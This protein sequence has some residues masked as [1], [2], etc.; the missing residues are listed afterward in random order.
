MSHRIDCTS[1]HRQSQTHFLTSDNCK[2]AKPLCTFRSRL[3]TE[4]FHIAYQDREA[5][6]SP[7]SASNSPM[8]SG[9]IINLFLS[10]CLS[11]TAMEEIRASWQPRRRQS[12]CKD[13]RGDELSVVI[14]I[15]PA[16]RISSK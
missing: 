7:Q 16:S 12:T 9:A 3:K 2:A 13:W 10:D 8:T 15:T 1:A 14:Q 5:Q 11:K 6:L 4:P